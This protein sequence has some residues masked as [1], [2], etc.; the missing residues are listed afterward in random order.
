M[1]R[2]L[3]DLQKPEEALGWLEKAVALGPSRAAALNDLGNLLQELGDL[4]EAEAAFRRV[5]E[6]EPNNADACSNLGTVLKGRGLVDEAADAYRQAIEFDYD[7]YGARYN[8]GNLFK[9]Q[10]RFEE[11]ASAY[12]EAVRVDS[13]KS[14]AHR[15]LC[16]ALKS[17]GDW[18]QA[19]EACRQW[20]ALEPEN[21][22]A[23][24]M[25]AAFSGSEAPARAADEYVVKV[26]DDFAATF[27]EQLA[28]LNNRGPQ[29]IA[30]ALAEEGLEQTGGLDVLDAGCGTG[31]C[32]PILRPYARRLI[33]VDLSEQM[34][35]RARGREIY[36]ELTAAEL[37]E[38]IVARPDS[39][40][41][42]VS[43]D[44]L[45]Y[46]GDLEPVLAAVGASLRPDGRFVFTLERLE[47]PPAA[48][49]GYQLNRHGRYAHWAE[50]VSD[51]V[52]KSGLR[53][54][55][56]KRVDLREQ[57]GQPVAGLVVSAVRPRE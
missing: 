47:T 35:Q 12:R 36:D 29:R 22:V 23:G 52:L 46:F 11:A 2:V 1:G 19:A 16:A 38:F 20:L 8:L 53:S 34:L 7:H 50:Y 6:L 4:E 41:L 43:A 42:I 13:G 14:D 17:L 3:Y 44:T 49:V 31:L 40:D 21:P 54:L 15:N 24:H 32:G 56:T 30:E 48:G 18:E 33:G 26:F 45:V 37:T 51:C 25:M 5:L 55:E 27:D 10:G 28:G 9:R 39:Y 57:A